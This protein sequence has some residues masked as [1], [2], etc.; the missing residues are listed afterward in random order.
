MC[1]KFIIKCEETADERRLDVVRYDK[2][3]GRLD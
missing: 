1:G 3:L 2:E